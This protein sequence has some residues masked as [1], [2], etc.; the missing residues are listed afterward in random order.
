MGCLTLSLPDFS[1]AALTPE[2]INQLQ[3][4]FKSEH[5]LQNKSPYDLTGKGFD[6]SNK[7]KDKN[8]NKYEDQNQNKNSNSSNSSNDSNNPGKNYPPRNSDHSSSNNQS[9]PN[10]SAGSDNSKNLI[11]IPIQDAQIS[12]R[13]Y[14]GKNLQTY[15]KSNQPSLINPNAKPVFFKPFSEPFSKNDFTN[16]S[17]GSGQPDSNFSELRSLL[18]NILQKWHQIQNNDFDLITDAC[19]NETS[20]TNASTNC[21]KHTSI[22]YDSARKFLLGKYYLVKDTNGYA[23]K[24]VYCSREYSSDEFKSQKPGPGIIPDNTVVN[25]EHT[26]PQSKFSTRYPP[27]IQKADLHH[28]YPADTKIN[29]IRGNN[30][31]GEVSQDE[32]TLKCD[33]SR[34]GLPAYGRYQVFEPPEEHK[35]HVARALFY[36]SVKYDKVI[37]PDQE[38]VLRQWHHDHPVDA[39]EFQRND[40]IYHTQ[41][42]RNPFVDYPNLVDQISDY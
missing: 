41:G 32:Q 4:N 18:K 16:P 37:D 33:V 3:K 34:F 5:G 35:G 20:A 11:Q 31:F 27:D 22:G 30:P 15:L 36:F 29:S 24:D 8:K 26:W 21:Y 12:R 19:E 2:Q 13:N 25:V 1:L 40:V 14:Y 23:V 38:S 39:D 6:N 7:N 28:L 17:Q 42:S 10:Y 9:N